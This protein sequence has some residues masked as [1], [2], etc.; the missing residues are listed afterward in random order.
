M[1]LHWLVYTHRFPFSIK[2][3]SNDI[4]AQT[5]TPSLQILVSNTTLQYKEPGSFGEMADSRTK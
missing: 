1:Y 4:A 3:A 2:P 5:R